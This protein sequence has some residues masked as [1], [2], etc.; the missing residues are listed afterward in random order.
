MGI[1]D[2]TANTYANSFYGPQNGAIGSSGWQV[3]ANLATPSYSAPYR[4]QYA[5]QGPYQR[6]SSPGFFSSAAT[7]V[8][9]FA[10]T[11]LFQSP[12]QNIDPY[13][14]SFSYKPYDAGMSLAQNFVLPGLAMGAANKYFGAKPAAGQATRSK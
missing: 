12:G 14:N 11:P 2:T 10:S 8:N 6:T 1:Y 13:V 9:P 7:L 5:G 4:P 3:D